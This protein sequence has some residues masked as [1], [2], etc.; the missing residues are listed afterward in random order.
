V[1]DEVMEVAHP[2]GVSEEGAPD[3]RSKEVTS[4]N[5]IGN[6]RGQRGKRPTKSSKKVSI[7]AVAISYVSEVEVVNR[8]ITLRR[9]TRNAVRPQRLGVYVNGERS[10]DNLED[11]STPVENKM[12]NQK[13][14]I[15]EK[16]EESDT[17]P[18]PLRATKKRRKSEGEKTSTQAKCDE[19]SRPCPQ[20]TTNGNTQ[21]TDSEVRL[22]R[23]AH[24]K[25]DPKSVSFW[26]DLSEL[27]DARSSVECRE[28][29]FSLVKTPVVP[30]RKRPRRSSAGVAGPASSD[31]DM[32]N[33]TPM[34]NMFAFNNLE[35]P[36]DAAVLG[37]IGNLSNLTL[38]SAIKVRE[39]SHHGGG[40]SS[41][42]LVLQNNP[43]KGY[44]TFIKA[45][46]RGVRR[47][48]T[49]RPP[50][51]LKAT[52]AGK[53]LAERVG[54]GDVEVKCQ[55]SPGGTLRVTTR[56]DRDDE[57]NYLDHDGEDEPDMEEVA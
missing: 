44:K 45:M 54:K 52:K 3:F 50:K 31:D 51:A 32:F 42:Q 46:K 11:T 35:Q 14:C 55:L 41:S 29:W 23:K 28:K 33:A 4:S 49:G 1:I 20:D 12:R 38:G 27:L 9:T 39:D 40:S 16:N 34:K 21:W 48:S 36:A 47:K 57:D 10:E 22:L 53:S 30:S 2:A 24:Q 5:K 56:S 8:H 37:Q 15:A 18:S 7:G 43:R 25:I 26:Q 13:K 17:N 19:R 6:Q